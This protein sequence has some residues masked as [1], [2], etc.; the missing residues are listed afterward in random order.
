M[1]QLSHPYMTTGKTIALTRWTFVSK[2]M[3]LLLNM[4]FR[5]VITFLPRSKCLLI[6]W[7]QSP[8]AVILE[9]R[10][11]KSLIVSTVAPI[12]CHEVMGPDAV[13]VVFWM[14]SF[15]P[16]F[17][18]SSF[19]FIKRL[20]SFFSLSAIRV[21]SSA[22]LRLLIFLLENLIPACASSSPAFHMMYSAYKLNKQGDSIQ[23]W[24][25]PFLIWNQFVVPCSVLTV[26]SW[27]AYRFLRRQVRWS[28]IPISWRI[29]HSLLWS[30]QRLW[31]S[32]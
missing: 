17:S 3:S 1:V 26:A 25:T 10:K 20:V 2:V 23:P 12:I 18:L 6:S 9:P 27:P 16:T 28:G 15:K 13:V 11:I 24:R 30:T 32:Q 5:V 8:S 14:L 31:H 19:T 7:L 21:V 29:F 22:Y 4:V